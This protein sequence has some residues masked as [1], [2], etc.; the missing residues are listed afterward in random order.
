[1]ISA[2]VAVEEAAVLLVDTIAP[3][4]LT[5]TIL[6]LPSCMVLA[7]P[8]EAPLPSAMELVTLPETSAL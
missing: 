8:V 2:P 4:V 7:D 1:M 6:P 3:A 5:F